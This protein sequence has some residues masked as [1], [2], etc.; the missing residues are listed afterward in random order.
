[1]QRH[2]FGRAGT[3]RTPVHAGGHTTYPAVSL[4][5][6]TT[7]P[8]LKRGNDEMLELW[9]YLQRDEKSRVKQRT[10]K[11]RK[12]VP[13]GTLVVATLGQYDGGH[14]CEK[15]FFPHR[16]EARFVVKAG[17]VLP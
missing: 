1:M 13:S 14:C 9:S 5:H 6:A 17:D 7:C 4:M 12:G 11:S 16:T 10:G 3:G 15:T 8:L 2:G